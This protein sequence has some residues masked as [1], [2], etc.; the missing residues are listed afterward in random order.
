MLLASQPVV[1]DSAVLTK[2]LL[3]AA[4]ASGAD[5]RQLAHEAQ[6]P[7][8]VL[9]DDRALLPSRHDMRLWELIEWSLDDP[10]AP[11]TLA[12][13]H[14]SGNL[15]IFDYL[16]T[17]AATLGDGLQ[18]R[19]DFLHLLTTNSRLDVEAETSRETTYSYWHVEPGGRGEELCLQFAVAVFCAQAS[20]ATGQRV[21]PA[22]V[23]VAA[24]AP[25]SHRAFTELL[26]TSRVDFGAPLTTLT[27]HT[28]DLEL[29]MRGA[30]PALARI[31]H[32]YAEALPPAPPA[33]WRE[34]FQRVLAEAIEHGSPSLEAV[35]RRLAVSVRTLQRQLATHGTTWRAE[36]DTARRRRA[37]RARQA[38][39]TDMIRLARQLGYLDPRS[40]RR[41]LR[42][43][44]QADNQQDSDPVKRRI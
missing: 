30:D 6:I 24:P 39:T 4:A 33:T 10:A 14:A 35:A 29:P 32:R 42:R 38:G 40:A 15:D 21:A 13:V 8:W 44:S 20:E 18:A 41:T 36:L 17:T 43:W 27:F 7:G 12:Q 19:R 22:H 31:L 5:A 16:F 34:H 11:L 25:R 2:S 37:E 9:A 3:A 26:G 1:H 28:A 23:S